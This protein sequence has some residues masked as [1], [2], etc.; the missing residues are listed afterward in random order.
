M[1]LT[2]EKS[3]LEEGEWSAE[4][5]VVKTVSMDLTPENGRQTRTVGR[6]LHKTIER[7]RDQTGRGR[8]ISVNESRRSSRASC[9]S[10]SPSPSRSRSPTYRNERRDSWR[11]TTYRRDSRA[12]YLTGRDS[13]VSVHS[14]RWSMSSDTSRRSF[15]SSPSPPRRG[16][17]RPDS[18]RIRPGTIITANHF[19]EADNQQVLD[20]SSTI[21]DVHIEE[22]YPT[23]VAL[24]MKSRPMIVISCHNKHFIALPSL[25]F[26]GR[27]LKVAHCPEE[28]VQ[29]RGPHLNRAE[30]DKYSPHP[31]ILVDEWQGMRLDDAGTDDP[32]TLK[33]L[34]SSIQLTSPF[35]VNYRTKYRE[36]GRINPES[37]RTLI[38]L[39]KQKS[40]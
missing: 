12:S 9:R 31:E 33:L 27:G 38:Q 7:L 25:T 14:S 26:G 36:I 39:Y 35:C 19:A 22:P 11:P 28:Y 15:S 18:D 5:L 20:G 17:I 6:F 4:D 24:Y 8:S 13:V 1:L 30:E 21:Y 10:R 40:A 3:P 34:E 37:L 32:A 29:L 2:R 16:S 23:T